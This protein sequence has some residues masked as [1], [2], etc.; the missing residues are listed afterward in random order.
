[1][2]YLKYFHLLAFL[3]NRWNPG[4]MIEGSILR[5]EKGSSVLTNNRIPNSRR[6]NVYY[7]NIIPGLRG[8]RKQRP[9]YADVGDKGTVIA[10]EKYFRHR[11]LHRV[12]R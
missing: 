12:S 11:Y 7:R 5:R 1:M 4:E 3:L 6:E 2:T 8:I 9:E 10:R